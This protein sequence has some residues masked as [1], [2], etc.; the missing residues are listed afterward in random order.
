MGT[1]NGGA[2]AKIEDNGRLSLPKVFFNEIDSRDQDFLFMTVE[3]HKCIIAYPHSV[4]EQR[5]GRL[6]SDGYEDD[7]TVLRQIRSMQRQLKRV[8]L[9]KQ[10]RIYI[11]SELKEKVGIDKEVE[12]V[13]SVNRF[14]IWDPKELDKYEQQ[15]PS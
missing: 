11:P 9:D 10:G 14:E 15:N 6:T 8:K 7:D 1:F 3:K 12:L 2:K 4:W 5:I 13:G